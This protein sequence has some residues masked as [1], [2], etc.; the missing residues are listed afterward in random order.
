MLKIKSKTMDVFLTWYLTLFALESKEWKQE[1][2]KE[3][4]GEEPLGFLGEEGDDFSSFSCVRKVV[5][6]SDF[7][8]YL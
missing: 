1:K 6:K 7:F 2:L 5:K 4:Q 3:G 8:P